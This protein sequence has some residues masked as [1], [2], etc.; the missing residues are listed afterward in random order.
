[1]KLFNK[2]MLL[3]AGFVCAAQASEKISITNTLPQEMPVAVTFATSKTAKATRPLKERIKKDK[4]VTFKQ[5][6]DRNWV[7]VTVYQ[8]GGYKEV[9]IQRSFNLTNPLF[10]NSKA[11]TI[12]GVSSTPTLWLNGKELA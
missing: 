10:G 4:T 2:M 1:M 8:A 5:P 6:L 11:I 3:S 9:K 7:T 12:E